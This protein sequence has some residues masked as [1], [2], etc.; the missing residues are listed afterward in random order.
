MRVGSCGGCDKEFKI[1]KIHKQCKH[2]LAKKH[3]TC[4]VCYQCNQCREMF[5]MKKEARGVEERGDGANR[6]TSDVV[7][8]RPANPFLDCIVN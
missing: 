3:R 4:D 7:R 8:I 5:M 2:R 1:P 6:N